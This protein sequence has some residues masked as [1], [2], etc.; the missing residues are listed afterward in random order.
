VT[1]VD[2][3]TAIVAEH[4]LY[5]DDE[6]DVCKCAWEPDY[7]QIDFTA[8]ALI[9]AHE[10]VNMLHARHV[11]ERIAAVDDLAVVEMETGWSNFTNTAFAPRQF[12]STSMQHL[13]RCPM[14]VTRQGEFEPCDK[15]AVAV[16]WV[17]F[18]DVE[19]ATPVCVAHCRVGEMVA[20][21]TLKEA[22]R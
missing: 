11:A 3:I 22:W 1:A 20:L 14:G 21:E 17:E 13:N 12:D 5:A 19:Y 2:R 7:E 10:H 18:E 4:A 16:R 8:N 15:P 6:R 9:P